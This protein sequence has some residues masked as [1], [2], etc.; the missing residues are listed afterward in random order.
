MHGD[1]ERSAA[2][3]AECIPL[4]QEIGDEPMV[5]GAVV[6]LAG[7]AL[8][9]DHP[10]ATAVLLGAADAEQQ[11][12]RWPRVAH[13]VPAA[14]IRQPVSAALPFEVWESALT[15]GRM[16]PIAEAV[17]AALDFAAHEDNAFERLERHAASFIAFTGSQDTH[18]VANDAREY[19]ELSWRELEVLSLLCQ[20]FT[21]LEM[22]QALF[23]GPRT[24]ESHVSHILTKLQVRNRRE[25]AALAV[26]RGLA[27]LPQH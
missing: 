19:P 3:F 25:A 13:P 6:G 9:G 23:V 24:I 18:S 27:P 21:N 11:A 26:K 15:G 17:A 8:H 1:L 5:M 12:T 7:V 20:R 4:A 16:L 2:Y 22:A 14:R 10:V